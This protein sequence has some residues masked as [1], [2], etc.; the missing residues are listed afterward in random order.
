[1]FGNTVF[2]FIYHH[3]IPGIIYPIRPQ[4]NLGKMFLTS[5]IVASILLFTEGMLA[6]L[7][8]SGLTNSCTPPPPA[9]TEFPCQVAPLFGENFTGI[10]VVG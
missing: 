2:V 1:V 3:S 6:Y 10:P 9:Q 8:F 4:T 7:A 5:N